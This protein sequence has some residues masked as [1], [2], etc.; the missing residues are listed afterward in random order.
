MKLAA[1]A[2]FPVATATALTPEDV[3][4]ADSDQ[5]TIAFDTE[6]NYKK[7]V[8]ADWYDHFIRARDVR[9][10]VE[11]AHFNKEGI[12]RI[13]LNPGNGGENPHVIVG[14]DADSDE[15]D[16]RRGEIAES[17]DDV[18]I[19]TIEEGGKIK[20]TSCDDEAA[21]ISSLPGSVSTS[22]GLDSLTNICT[23]GSRF[24][25]GSFQDFA[26]GWSVASH[27]M[28]HDLIVDSCKTEWGVNHRGSEYGTI[29]LWDHSLDIA[30]IEPNSVSNPVSE[31]VYPPDHSTS[32][33]INGTVSESGMGTVVNN[34]L[35]G[36]IWGINSCEVDGHYESINNTIDVNH[37]CT[38][39]GIT[40]QVVMDVGSQIP[41]HGDSG[42][43]LQV[44]EPDTND[45]FAT[46]SLSSG[47]EQDNAHN[48]VWGPQG[49]TI[50]DKHNIW[51]DDLE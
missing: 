44:Q 20:W 5:V 50:R 31:V 6:G 39:D 30:Y 16:E 49:F 9:D 28:H 41:E 51:W 2:G 8:P 40:D 45:W 14:L 15:K 36:I 27:C 19:K 42:A 33:H 32:H 24:I 10:K 47:I 13:G 7:Q 22:I 48:F 34:N 25:N 11:K 35:S 29:V 17:R 26:F 46:G 43:V 23:N 1:A 21:D 4:A 38:S 3:Q 37:P 12:F 18:N